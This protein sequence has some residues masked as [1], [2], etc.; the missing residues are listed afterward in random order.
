MDKYYT[1]YE[2]SSK[3]IETESIMVAARSRGEGK[4]GSSSRA[5]ISLMQDEEVPGI[6]CINTLI[7]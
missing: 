4:M 2:K 1:K 5:K 3:L 6:F 7:L